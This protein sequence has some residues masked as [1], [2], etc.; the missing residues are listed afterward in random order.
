MTFYAFHAP[1][2][3]LFFIQD[4]QVLLRVKIPVHL[5][6]ESAYIRSEPDNEEYLSPMQLVSKDKHWQIWQGIL[7]LDIAQEMTLYCFKFLLSKTQYWLSEMG[8]SHY[9]PERDTHYRYNPHYQAAK[10]VWS[11]IFYQIF[12]ERFADGDS[13][14]NVKSGEY[15][16]EGKPVVAKAW[17]EL[18]DRKQGP[19]EFYGGD[20][21][22]I[23][24]R[25]D[26]LQDLGVTALYLNPIFT[27]PSSHKYDTVDYHTVDPHFG[28][29]EAFAE[30]CKTLQKRGIRL[31]LDA[32]VNHTS[33]RHPW[34]DR[35]GEYETG[36]YQSKDSETRGFY[37]FQTDDSESYVGWYNVKTLPVL[38]FGSQELQRRVYQDKNSI[39]RKWMQ[40]PYKI[41]GW[42]FDVMHMLGEG[43]GAKNNHVY[44]KAFRQALREENSESY[45]LGEHFF[46]ASKWLQGDQEDAAMNYY[47]FTRP[48]REFLSGVDFRG[49]AVSIAAGDL[50]TM[51]QRARMKI[52]FAL[53]LSQFNLLG[54]H[55]VP[56]VLT[57]LGGDI[58]L[59]KIAITALF[60]YIGVP[61][62]YYGDEV[63][64]EGGNDPDCRRTFPWDKS[65][66][67]QDLRETYTQLVQLR[68][69]SKVLQEGAFLSLYAKDDVYA[70]A[71]VLG[72]EAIITILNR[73]AKIS[74]ELPVW[75]LGIVQNKG[76]LKLELAEKSAILFQT[77]DQYQISS[78]K[79][80]EIRI[81]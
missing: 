27:S 61:C 59:L 4:G 24:Q 73:G 31:I 6:L 43:H 52:P 18:P 37:I 8:L 47:G 45:M 15:L 11:Q 42:R 3:D 35:Y 25:L 68:K 17:G 72:H 19:R 58:A 80:K 38:D 40:E 26:Y 1:T 41:D 57:V 5:K 69:R 63:G 29:N 64:L 30:L 21:E 14:N 49:H 20:L 62:I 66:W 60:T 32:V 54:S 56:R 44:A 22:G 7:K 53:Q 36:A 16:Y 79:L 9:F 34:F 65:L 2:P 55:D 51:L 39:L 28:G 74:I 78:I 67:N 46:E 50:D 75:K 33:E 48:L 13:S 10:W 70:Y 77:N 76:L 71:R 12:P 23:G 81:Q